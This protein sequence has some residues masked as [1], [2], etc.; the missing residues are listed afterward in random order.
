MLGKAGAGF[1][2]L[3]L[4]W[5]L[6][7][8]AQAAAPLPNPLAPKPPHI[9]GKAKSVIFLFMDGGP[10]HIDTFD[11]KPEVNRL[12]GKPLPSHIK[13]SFTAMGVSRNPILTSK[14]KFTNYGQSG[15]PVSDWMP[16]TGKCADQLCVVRSMWA[17]GI[18]HVGSVCQMNT[19]SVLAGRASMGSWVTY[20]LGSENQDLPSFVVMLDN[21]SEPPGGPRNWGTGFVPATYQGTRFLNGPSPVLNLQPPAGVTD[22]RQ[23]EKL[24]LLNELNRRHA[25]ERGYNSDLEGRIAA[26]ELSYRMQAAAPEAVELARESAETKELYGLN[27]KETESFGRLCLLSRRM[28]ERGVRFVQLYSGSGSKWDAHSKIEENHTKYCLSCDKPIAGLI[29]DLARRGMLDDTLVVWGGEF[30]RTPMSE[31][32]DG[33]DHNPYGFSMWMAGGGV[34]AGH[35][36]GATDEC[37]MHAIEDRIHVHDLHATIL[38]LLGL[39][40]ERLT[41][42]H[43]GLDERLT[44]NKGHVVTKILA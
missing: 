42:P 20:G 12:A 43:N 35:I 4:S 23:R 17:D 39:D 37:G 8:D 21:E 32:G 41:Y 40:H 11:P 15:I 13:A 5:M 1:G 36:V 18:N 38:H 33:R 14:R 2:S 3:A 10:S 16:E 31:K 44:M 9:G 27:R 30:G 19:G 28:V 25:R 7:R 34:K 29:T 6:Q 24:D 22:L 26:Y